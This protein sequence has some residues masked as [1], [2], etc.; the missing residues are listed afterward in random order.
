MCG[1]RTLC[2]LRGDPEGIRVVRAL[3]DLLEAQDVTI[4]L[5]EPGSRVECDVAVLG[6]EGR[7]LNIIVRAQAV[8]DEVDAWRA[9]FKALSHPGGF[10]SL[11]VGLDPGVT[12]SIAAY[13]DNILVWVEKLDC[14]SVGRRIKWL[15]EVV[16]P[17]RYNVNV[18]SGPGL[19][20]LLENLVKEGVEF[21]I[22][23]EERTTTKPVLSRLREHV[24]DEDILAAMTIALTH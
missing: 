4:V 17:R 18:G 5:P 12:C 8:V 1:L 14:G 6:V 19:E 3:K 11:R 16:E 22:V 13:A 24:K 23:P 20:R 2:W 15:V 9:L 21:N 10:R 7:V